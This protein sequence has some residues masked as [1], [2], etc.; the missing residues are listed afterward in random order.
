MLRILSLQL[1]TLLPLRTEARS[2]SSNGGGG[3]SGICAID[4]PLSLSLRD[5]MPIMSKV[6]PLV[7][8]YA[9]GGGAAMTSSS[10][11]PVPR[12]FIVAA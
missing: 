10:T 2:L 12:T 1:T 3:E 6:L 4:P 11:S 8:P 5:G 7:F 9:G